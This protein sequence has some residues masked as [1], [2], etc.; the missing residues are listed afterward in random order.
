MN[1]ALCVA[2][3]IC[4]NF[5]LDHEGEILREVQNDREFIWL[6]GFFGLFEEFGL[7]RRNEFMRFQ[8]LQLMTKL[9]YKFTGGLV[10]DLQRASTYN[11][12]NVKS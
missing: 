6:Q 3:M 1:G 5:V 7:M 4:L 2:P 11:Q 9:V 12:K 10:Y 8:V